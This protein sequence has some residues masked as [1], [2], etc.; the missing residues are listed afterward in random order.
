MNDLKVFKNELQWYLV[1]EDI[2]PLIMEDNLKGKPIIKL[3]KKGGNKTGKKN[4][5]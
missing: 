3:Y 2:K 1:K 4:D 5:K